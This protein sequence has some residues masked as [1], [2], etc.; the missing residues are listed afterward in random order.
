MHHHTRQLLPPDRAAAVRTFAAAFADDPAICFI[1]PD[2]AERYRR[3]PAVM[4]LIWDG[5]MA[6]P[7][8]GGTAW[9]TTGAEAVTLWLPSTTRDGP[10]PG[11]IGLLRR[12]P[13]LWRVF[14]TAVR[15]ALALGDALVANHPQQPHAYLHFAACHPSHQGKGLG[16]AAIRAGLAASP[17]LPAF[18]ETANEANLG[19]YRAL[20][21]AVVS[22]YRV[23]RGPRL[24]T[25]TRPAG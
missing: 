3:R 16:G 14:G 23:P 15:R 25:M 20:G 21:F 7:A 19:L 4:E 12:A 9:A 24:W 11:L 2:A 17:G 8:A 6:D 5:D 13:R 10:S 22:D 18:L 1:W